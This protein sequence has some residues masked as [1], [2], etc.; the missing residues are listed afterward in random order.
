VVLHEC[1]PL[2][3]ALHW[4][5]GCCP[6]RFKAFADAFQMVPGA[7]KAIALRHSKLKSCSMSSIEVYSLERSFC[8]DNARLNSK[9]LLSKYAV[10]VLADQHAHVEK[11]PSNVHP[12]LF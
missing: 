2:K 6:L 4:A 11:Y 3:C 5:I 7:L 12:A 8:G 1:I 10:A 9:S